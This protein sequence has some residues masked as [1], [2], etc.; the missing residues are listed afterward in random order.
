MSRYI[1]DR[2]QDTMRGVSKHVSVG[3]A[4]R[5]GK[6]MENWFVLCRREPG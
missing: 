5:D 1:Y 4:S 2:T 6:L 3:R